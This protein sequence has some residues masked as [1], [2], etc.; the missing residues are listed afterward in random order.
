LGRPVFNTPLIAGRWQA[1]RLL[2]IIMKIVL[3]KGSAEYQEVKRPMVKRD[4]Q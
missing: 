4:P 2:K 1:S 3:N